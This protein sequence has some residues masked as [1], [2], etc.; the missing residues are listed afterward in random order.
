MVVI[1]SHAADRLAIFIDNSNLMRGVLKDPANSRVNYEVLISEL[2]AGRHLRMVR[3]YDTYKRKED[4]T[5]NTG[6]ETHLRN[7]GI[8]TCFRDSFN[9]ECRTQKEIDTAMSIDICMLAM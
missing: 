3:V 1:S 5:V 9:P 4:G 7:L 2:K 6:L 8:T